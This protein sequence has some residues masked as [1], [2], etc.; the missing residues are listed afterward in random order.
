MSRLPEV[1][2]EL[3]GIATRRQLLRRGFTGRQLTAAVRAG[4]VRRVR[5]GYYASPSAILDRLAAVRLGGRL[6]C[7]SATKSFGLWEVSESLVH[8]TLPS[9]AARL[10][11]NLA[12][13][14][15]LQTLTP[16]RFGLPVKLHWRDLRVGQRVGGDA[17]RVDLAT[18]LE[19]VARCAGRRDIRAVFESAI[20][21]RLLTLDAAQ[22]LLDDALPR[23]SAPMRLS[24]LSGSGA[25]SHVVE[26]LLDQGLPFVQQVE[27][28]GIGR[29]DFLVA[30][31]LVVEV[32]GYEFH[33][34]NEQFEKDRARDATLLGR[35][36]PTVRIPARIVLREPER[37]V[38]MIRRAV[39]A[40][41]ALPAA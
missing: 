32:D 15:G 11:T 27:F 24:G 40:M 25:E 20:H 17:W 19:D 39:L 38:D 5:Q 28:E 2:D 1:L 8:V 35:G 41:D 33:R 10:R 12:L 21:A 18:A 23:G 30:G 37:A 22:R 7:L 6:G 4:S 16:D 13:P 34:S 31:R 26:E 3:G 14:A 9:N 36:Y 29:V